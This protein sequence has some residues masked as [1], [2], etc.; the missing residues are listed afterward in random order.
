MFLSRLAKTLRWKITPTK[1]TWTRT[2]RCP[3]MK[4]N[5]FLSKM[6]TT[7]KTMNFVSST[8]NLGANTKFHQDYWLPKASQIVKEMR[9]EKREDLYRLVVARSAK[10]VIL[11]KMAASNSNTALLKTLQL[12]WKCHSPTSQCQFPIRQACQCSVSRHLCPMRSSHCNRIP[13]R[14][15]W[16]TRLH[17]NKSLLLLFRI[18]QVPKTDTSM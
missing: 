7:S 4:V 15:L 3:V 1:K 8:C 14:S 13:T 9:K 6:I 16:T 5:Q 2:V 10:S 17:N 11:S 12:I 18:G